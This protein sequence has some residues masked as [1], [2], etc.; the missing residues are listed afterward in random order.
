MPHSSRLPVLALVVI[1]LVLFTLTSFHASDP[2]QEQPSTVLLVSLDG[3]RA[4]YLEWYQPAALNQLAQEGVRAEYLESVF[5]SSTFPNHYTLMT[6]R[7]PDNH[8]IISNRMTDSELGGFSPSNR[9]A[10]RDGRWW[11][12][13]EPL[14][15]TLY[16]VGIKSG[17]YF[18]PGSEAAI[19]GVRPAEYRVFDDSTPWKTRINWAL[20]ALARPETERPRLITLYFG[21]A[22]QVGHQHGPHGDHMR[23]AVENVDKYVGHLIQNLDEAGLL[24]Q[25]NLIITSDHGMVATSQDSVVILD[26]FI[27]LKE[28]VIADWNPVLALRPADGNETRLLTKL[29]EIPH[30]AFYRKADVPEHLHY[31]DHGRIQPIIGI[32]DLGWLVASRKA[33]EVN[34]RLF[35][36]GAHGYDPTHSSMRGIF[37]ARGP[38]FKQGKVV[39]GFSIVHVYALLCEVLGVPPEENDGNLDLVQHLLR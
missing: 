4:D 33:F 34:P 29:Q 20:E 19:H 13:A 38:A 17:I 6:G 10:I 12:D 36:G 35:D 14:W 5:P 18:W 9:D 25:I 27:D 2:T 24:D 26:D 39:E 11:D 32:P 28:M 7:Y 3:F 21:E 16:K 22:D 30:F 15:V 8:G 31:G 23:S 37:I 1:P